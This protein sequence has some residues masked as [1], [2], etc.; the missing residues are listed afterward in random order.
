M[1]QDTDREQKIVSHWLT[2]QSVEVLNPTLNRAYPLDEATGF[3]AA[4]E[5]IDAAERLAWDAGGAAKK[6]E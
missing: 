6:P 4:L 2:R 3:D 5:A 1:S